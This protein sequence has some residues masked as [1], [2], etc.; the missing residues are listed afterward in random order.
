M[1]RWQV[2]LIKA[3][4]WAACLTPLFWLYL[5]IYHDFGGFVANPN[6]EILHTVGKTGL[7]LL[8]IT[9]AVTPVRHLTKF[10]LLIRFRRLLGLFTFFYLS[11]HLYAFIWLD[12]AYRWGIILDEIV[13]RPY[14]TIGMLA[15]ALMIPLAVTSTR[16]MQRRLG[17]RWVKLHRLIYPIGILGVWH[18]WWHGKQTSNEPLLYAGILTVL[19][20]YRIWRAWSR[21]RAVSRP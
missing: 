20:G 17:R 15:L 12:L 4:V 9:L 8:L 18:F 11:L 19:L 21:K 5:R 2:G 10:N 13:I 16:A 14:L 3:I 6:S 7:N 1:Q